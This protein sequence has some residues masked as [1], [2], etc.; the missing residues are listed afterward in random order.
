MGH[1][2]PIVL[3]SLAA[4]LSAVDQPATYKGVQ[5]GLRELLCLRLRVNEL[6]SRQTTAVEPTNENVG[7]SRTLFGQR[8]RWIRG[9]IHTIDRVGL[10][11]GIQHRMVR[12]KD[13]N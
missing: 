12:I 13:L 5:F 9:W 4:N 8:D 2:E 3:N 6:V 11:H 1:C 7:I 10:E